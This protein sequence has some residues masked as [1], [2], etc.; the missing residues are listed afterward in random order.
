M[1]AHRRSSFASWRRCFVVAVLALAGLAK[2]SAPAHAGVYS[3]YSCDASGRVDG[4]VPEWTPDAGYAALYTCADG[5]MARSVGRA[6]KSLAPP[7]SMGRW[8]FRAP[9]G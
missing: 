5:M 1:N 2:A 9:A 7:T 6:D 4:W 3:V 8:A